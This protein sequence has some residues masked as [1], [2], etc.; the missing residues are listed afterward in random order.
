MVNLRKKLKIGT[1]SLA[2]ALA[3]AACGGGGGGGSTSTGGGGGGGGGGTPP[4]PIDYNTAEYRRSWGLDAINA[5]AAY[6]AG[7]TGAGVIVAVIDSGIDLQHVDLDGN[8]HFLSKDMYAGRNILDAE[9]DHGTLV[10]G[11]IAAERNNL[12][13]LGVAFDAQILALRTD[14]P[15][16]CADVDGCA[17]FDTKI[18]EAI[19]YAVAS[20]ADVINISLGGP[21]ASLQVLL[22]AMADAVA[23]G[24]I[25]VVSAGNDG[26]SGAAIPEQSALD[27]I[28]AAGPGL[29][30]IAGSVDE[31]LIL[32]TFSNP[33]GAD[34]Q[35]AESFAVAPG[36]D[37]VMS[38]LDDGTGTYDLWLI[39]GT[40]F[41]APH[42]AG[43]AAL[44]LDAF[45]NLTPTEVVELLL[46]TAL[47]LG[48][49]GTDALYGR[50]LIDIAEAM[51]PQGLLSVQVKTTN[52]IKAVTLANSGLV[53]G[54]AFGDSIGRSSSLSSSVFSDSYDRGYRTD[55]TRRALAAD[56]LVDFASVLKSKRSYASSSM[57]LGAGQTFKVAVTKQ[58][59]GQYRND[60]GHLLS[61]DGSMLDYDSVKFGWES[62]FGGE[63]KVHSILGESLTDNLGF[64]GEAFTSMTIDQSIN[65]AASQNAF[66]SGSGEARRVSVARSFG[67]IQFAVGVGTVDIPE[68]QTGYAVAALDPASKSAVVAQLSH[69]SDGGSWK[70]QMGYVD[71]ENM[72]LGSRGAGALSLGKGAQ[73]EFI[74]LSGAWNVA[75]DIEVTGSVLAGNTNAQAVEASIFK[76]ASS[77]SSLGY[78][79]AISKS[80]IFQDRDRLSFSVFQ[81]LRVESGSIQL[82][83]PLAWDWEEEKALFETER[84]SLNPSGREMDMEMS[85]TATLQGGWQV[86]ANLLHQI[87]PGH[88]AG[89]DAETSLLVHAR[90]GF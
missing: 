10:A 17:F 40:S 81:P 50:G 48:A 53:T 54:P 18:A 55:L 74:A 85:Y 7:A 26:E 37:I 75:P 51:S 46:T 62:E 59:A 24:V 15:G 29:V 69:E 2:L 42:V 64:S 83:A 22:D 9:D 79:A 23:A 21:D 36:E 3:L 5:I 76:E 57:S 86:Q 14:D 61:G 65:S 16:S 30:I 4:P 44:L 19:D 52:G 28:N 45:P 78:K 25:I 31:N 8:V 27:A 49:P 41:A 71:E 73:S 63:L 56:P 6:D 72:V 34:L 47:D 88:V 43:A 38:L 60:D 68:D 12:Y 67:G 11:V 84:L 32:S 35:Y 33:A 80:G 58:D 90:W 87:E 82:E 66:L 70:V 39:S 77:I 20:G 1:S 89:A 13:T